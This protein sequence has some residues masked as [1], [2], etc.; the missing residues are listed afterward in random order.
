MKVNPQTR[1]TPTATKSIKRTL[2]E[3]GEES[4]QA[5]FQ[6]IRAIVEKIVVHPGGRYEPVKLQIFGQLAAILRLSEA[7]GEATGSK[8]ALV[9]GARFELATFRL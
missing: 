5:A 1:R 8:G 3:A 2:A 6:G 7:A 9:A 4:R